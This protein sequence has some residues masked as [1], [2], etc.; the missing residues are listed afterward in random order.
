MKQPRIVKHRLRPLV[1][2]LAVG[3]L[4][5]AQQAMA[6]GYV[7]S[8][9]SRSFLCSAPGGHKNTN[10]GNIQYEPQSLEHATGEPP[11]PVN[12][13]KDGE[14]ASADQTRGPELDEQTPDRWT[15]TDIKSGPN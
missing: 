6:H 8:P 14:I 12:G 7:Q 1:S 5:V 4:F 2:L 10:C 9:P 3:G 15:K 13:P 11:F